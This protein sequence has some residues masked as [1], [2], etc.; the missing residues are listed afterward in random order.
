MCV[1]ILVLVIS[2]NAKRLHHII[3]LLWPVRLYSSFPDLLT[4]DTIFA[5]TLLNMECVFWF[6]QSNVC[7]K[8]FS[9][10]Q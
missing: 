3:L 2:R 6:F 5:N 4:N 1:C 10:Y 7:L 9:F 8:Y